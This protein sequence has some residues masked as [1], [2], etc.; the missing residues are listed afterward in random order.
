MILFCFLFLLRYSRAK[1]AGTSTSFISLLSKG[2]LLASA[3]GFVF[4]LY[5]PLPT[6]ATDLL[7]V[8]ILHQGQ[9]LQIVC[10]VFIDCFGDVQDDYGI[11]NIPLFSIE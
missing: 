4:G 9:G 11:I 1:I 6:Y 2:P 8:L 7:M 5:H 10:Y 3:L